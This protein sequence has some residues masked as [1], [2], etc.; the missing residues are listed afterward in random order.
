MRI[1]R[2][3]GREFFE[4]LDLDKKC[5][6]T[7]LCWGGWVVA[8]RC[9][10]SSPGFTYFIAATRVLLL[11]GPPEYWWGGLFCVTGGL[12]IHGR[13]AGIFRLRMSA[14]I[15]ACTIWL[16]L[17]AAFALQNPLSTGIPMYSLFA[18]ANAALYYQVGTRR[19]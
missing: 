9:F 1:L 11:P 8:T 7:A 2:W 16:A 15:L 10:N 17:A 18:F 6:L 12:Q 13:F 5:A 3:L 4:T 14:A 19:R